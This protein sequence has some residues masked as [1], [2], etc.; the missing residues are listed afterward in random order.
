MTWHRSADYSAHA[1]T[2]LLGKP[3]VLVVCGSGVKEL[4][5]LLGEKV[6]SVEMCDVPAWPVPV[7]QGHGSSIQAIRVESQLV[8]VATGRVH[9]Y[10]GLGVDACAHAVRAAH[11]AGATKVVLTN[12]AGSLIEAWQPGSVV[13]VEDHVNLLGENPLCGEQPDGYPRFV[14]LDDAYDEAMLAAMSPLC[15]GR[16][17]YA[18]MRGPSYETKAE[19]RML[20]SYGVS[21]V[22]MSSIPEALA[23]RQ[24]GMRVA[25]ISVVSNMATGMT[26]E[27]GSHD[28]VLE[29]VKNATPRLASVVR[30]AIL[31]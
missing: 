9:L 4:P 19:I 24:A 3:D 18:S 12:A 20:S 26:S 1:L 31:A 17:V 23:A 5:G 13:A 30:A 11:L 6:A 27:A 16:G 22:G 15:A 7:A 8:W 14:P 2:H 25:T 10:D 28:E 29:M 21:L